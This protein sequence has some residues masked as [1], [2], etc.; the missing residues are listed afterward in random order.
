MHKQEIGSTNGRR[1]GKIRRLKPG[2]KG[3]IPFKIPATQAKLV[4]KHK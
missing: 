3:Y 2:L 4:S 1:K